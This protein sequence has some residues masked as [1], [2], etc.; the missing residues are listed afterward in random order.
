LAEKNQ[1]AVTPRVI[2]S[3]D[4]IKVSLESKFNNK[5]E[6]VKNTGEND[7]DK[8]RFDTLALTKQN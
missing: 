5:Y 8:H 1:M 7:D 2:L 4:S 3:D 6:L